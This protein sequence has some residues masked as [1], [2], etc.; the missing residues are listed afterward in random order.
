MLQHVLITCHSVPL[1]HHDSP[2]ISLTLYVTGR[3]HDCRSVG[4]RGRGRGRASGAN[5]AKGDIH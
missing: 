1:D 3:Y 5:A 4:E 2:Y